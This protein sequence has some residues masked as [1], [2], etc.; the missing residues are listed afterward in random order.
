MAT[1]NVVSKPDNWTS[2]GDPIPYE[3][4]YESSELRTESSNKEKTT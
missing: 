2:I 4:H 1:L 3:I